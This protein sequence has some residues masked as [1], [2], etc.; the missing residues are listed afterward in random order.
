M[1]G[2]KK[3]GKKVSTRKLREK[4]KSTH[5]RT[6]GN[7]EIKLGKRRGRLPRRLANGG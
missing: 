7:K 5:L 2:K 6:R 1:R 3:R 4:R